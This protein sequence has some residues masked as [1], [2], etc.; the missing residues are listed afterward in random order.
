MINQDFKAPGI[1][2]Q[3]L[4]NFGICCCRELAGLKVTS[5]R[6]CVRSL[7][8]VGERMILFWV[9]RRAF[10]K[11]NGTL[12]CQISETNHHNTEFDGVTSVQQC[13]VLW[14]SHNF[15]S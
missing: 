1:K 7:C 3:V 12:H 13:F 10:K 14:H 5:F 6:A 9:L 15:L 4:P 2:Y 11:V 8:S